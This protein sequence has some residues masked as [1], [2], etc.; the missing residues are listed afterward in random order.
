MELTNKSW[1]MNNILFT[2]FGESQKREFA[3]KHME[4][5]HRG[6]ISRT[7]WGERAIERMPKMCIYIKSGNADR[8][9]RKRKIGR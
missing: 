7:L 9:P 2:A 4:I 6:E 3:S 5:F 1:S 8:I